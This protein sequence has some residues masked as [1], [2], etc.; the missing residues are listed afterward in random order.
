MAGEIVYPSRTLDRGVVQGANDIIRRLRKI[1][2]AVSEQEIT[3]ILRE[4]SQPI[5]DQ[6]ESLANAQGIRSEGEPSHGATV[7]MADSVMVTVV[8]DPR[9]FDPGIQA[10]IGPYAENWYAQ[11]AEYG[12]TDRKGVK[13]SAR[14]FLRPAFEMNATSAE[15]YIINSLWA[16][17]QDATVGAPVGAAA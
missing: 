13:H 2:K 5:R 14:P 12:F 6:A 17:I 9:G 8:R 10:R 7:H 11:F 1:G 16:L 3:L 4:A 15:R